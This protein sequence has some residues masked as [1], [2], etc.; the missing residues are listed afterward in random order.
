[1][2]MLTSRPSMSVSPDDTFTPFQE[3][4]SPNKHVKIK[5]EFSDDSGTKYAFNIQ[6]TSKENIAKLL[7]FAQSVSSHNK[8][9]S[10]DGPVDTNFAK[11]YNLLESKFR[12]GS[13][14]SSDVLEAYQA[15]F[16]V[17]TTLSIIST[18][19]SRLARRGLLLRSKHGS[20][21]IYKL[22]KKQDHVK[23]PIPGQNE[24]PSLLFKNG[25]ISP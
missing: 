16:A 10:Q 12:F 9:G 8:Q 24:E 7:D 5:I 6:G 15:D 2:H 19:L 14:T 11:L 3:P 21:W 20:G 4:P 23:A 1:M 22:P 25:D 17:P 18:Y 13:F